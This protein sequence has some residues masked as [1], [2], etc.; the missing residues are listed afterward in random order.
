M[1]VYSH[2]RVGPPVSSPTF[3]V[4]WCS[5]KRSSPLNRALLV[6]YLMARQRIVG[7]LESEKRIADT[8]GLMIVDSPNFSEAGNFLISRETSPTVKRIVP[9]VPMKN[10]ALSTSFFLAIVR[11][12]LYCRRL[13]IFF[14]ND[15]HISVLITYEKCYVLLTYHYITTLTGPPVMR[16]LSPHLCPPSWKR[17][18]AAASYGVLFAITAP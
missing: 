1:H 14:G 16:F 10:R 4:Q 8:Y 2:H 6:S 11:I 17:H 9:S 15:L 3:A 18:S 5:N 12:M 7:L 13:A